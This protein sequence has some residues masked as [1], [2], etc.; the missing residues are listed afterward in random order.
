MNKTYDNDVIDAPDFNRQPRSGRATWDERGNSIWEWQT[1]PGVFSREINPRQLA[2]LEANHLTLVDARQGDGALESTWVFVAGG[3]HMSTQRMR[4][5]EVVMSERNKP[6]PKAG[7]FDRFL[8]HL[9]L[10]A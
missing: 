5:S 7:A 6:L 3:S 8:K 4:S 1:A 2:A 9:G 10:P